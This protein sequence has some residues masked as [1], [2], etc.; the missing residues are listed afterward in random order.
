MHRLAKWERCMATCRK[1]LWV[2]R[3]FLGMGNLSTGSLSYQD[4]SKFQ[5]CGL[6]DLTQLFVAA[7]GAMGLLLK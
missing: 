6:P 1:L 2:W 3:L 4:C 7:E 5:Q